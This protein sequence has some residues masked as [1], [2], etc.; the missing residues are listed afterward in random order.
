M[1]N[2]RVKIREKQFA[3]VATREEA[4]ALVRFITKA[5]AT[6]RRLKAEL[7]GK[8]ADLKKTYEGNLSE[9]AEQISP[10]VES[11]RAWAESNPTEFNGKKSLEML[12]GTIGWRTSPP[13][14]KTAKGFTWAAVLG[15]LKD[16]GHWEFVRTKEEV[17]KEA[18][19]AARDAQNL[20]A[21]YLRIEQAEEFFV[22]PKM[23]DS[24]NRETL[25]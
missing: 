9:I 14:L 3:V 13:A 2:D 12:S 11:L 20:K 23:T 10:C 17:N 1:K 4:E 7:D 19:L 22:D 8:V 5:K 21:M 24:T 18:I 16:L 15:R 6:E 25:S